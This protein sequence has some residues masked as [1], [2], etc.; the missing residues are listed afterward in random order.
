MV[1][2]QLTYDMFGTTDSALFVVASILFYALSVVFV[3][4]ACYASLTRSVTKGSVIFL[5]VILWLAATIACWQV[6]Y[7]GLALKICI[8][9]LTLT[10]NISW[11]SF[12][13]ALNRKSMPSVR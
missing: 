8:C 13:P 12:G 5:S 1:I 4:E 3:E 6:A 2:T 11:W 10:L 9:L 7:F